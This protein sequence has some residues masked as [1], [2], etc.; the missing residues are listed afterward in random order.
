LDLR[1]QLAR[2]AAA[3][4]T[5]PGLAAGA[6]LF[7]STAFAQ[8]QP[9]GCTIG[10][11]RVTE[12]PLRPA[13]IN[14]AGQVA[15][16]T[17]SHR[18]AVWSRAAG[19]QELPL[20]AGYEHA[21]AVAINSRGHV[22][23]MAYDHS[24]IKH[25][26]FVFAGNVLRLLPGDQAKVFHINDVDVV[27]GEALL[28]G[29]TKTEPVL[30]I[31]G[32]VRALGACCG[33]SARSVDTRGDVVGDAYDEQGR[34]YAFS[35]SEALGLRA[36]GPPDRYSS[37]VAANDQAHVLIQ[38]LS[39]V[40]LYSDGSMTRLDLAPKTPSHALAINNCDLVVGSFGPFADA[41]RA[42]AWNQGG[43]FQNLNAHIPSDAGWKLEAATGVNNRGQIVGKGDPPG[44]DESG[45][46]LE[47]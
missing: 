24:F 13:A 11:Y 15:G 19:L 42:F 29:K 44:K 9:V 21:E 47:P 25:Q 36:I 5:L 32:K 16:T 23:G 38:V 28:P 43:G 8:P 6:L 17:E 4:R 26:A 22:L 35:W 37:A 33:G 2:C 39:Q 27:A 34:Y 18:A 14:D 10:E 30:W 3:G 46:L 31:D 41:D 1:R 7:A 45:F 40:F 12:L 20:P